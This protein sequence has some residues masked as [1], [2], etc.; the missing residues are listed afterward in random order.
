MKQAPG[1]LYIGSGEEG[2]T[3]IELDDA[4]A[5]LSE[6]EADDLVMVKAKASAGANSSTTSDFAA[7]V[8]DVLG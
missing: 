8:L 3:R 6:L 1:A 4:R 7:R 2:A 5:I